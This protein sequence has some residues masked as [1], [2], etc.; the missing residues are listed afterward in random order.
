MSNG[1]P[2]DPSKT[3]DM[4]ADMLLEESTRIVES[5]V[6]PEIDLNTGIFLAEC[7]YF[8]DKRIRETGKL[9]KRWHTPRPTA[10]LRDLASSLAAEQV[11]L[12]RARARA[13][14]AKAAL[15]GILA[16]GGPP[17]TPQRIAMVVFN[18]ADAMLAEE[19]ERAKEGR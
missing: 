4:L 9:P 11:A 12:S 17:A 5:K 16:S 2:S 6:D 19:I 13:K 7:A 15:T 10:T 8:L 1:E 3:A 14:Y 18:M